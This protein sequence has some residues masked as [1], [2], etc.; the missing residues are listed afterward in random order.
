MDVAANLPT[1]LA[2]L[3]L[4][5]TLL[6]LLVLSLRWFRT[7]GPRP[8][9]HLPSPVGLAPG[10]A[11]AHTGVLVAEP[12]GR[13]VANGPARALFGL[14]G[15]QPTLSAVLRPTQP[16]DRLLELLAAEGQAQ[17][18]IGEH[19]VDATSHRVPVPAAGPDRIVVVLRE[20]ERP[21][22]NLPAGD[23][24]GAAVRAL[25]EIN[26]RLSAS[27]DVEETCDA[28]M[29][30]LAAAFQYSLAELNLWDPTAQVLR[31]AR[32]AGDQ[33]Y[34]RDLERAGATYGPDEGYSGWLA[35]HRAPLC[36]ENIP[37]FEAA[38]PKLYGA[39]FPFEAYLGVPLLAG[40]E[41]V[42]TLEL[43][44]YRPASFRPHD[45]DFLQLVAGQAA[46]A[47]RNAQR[48]A[49]EQRRA[50]E[51]AGL[52]EITR[53]LEAT[54]DARELFGR[55]TSDIARVMD[56]EMAALL[57]HSARTQALE[58]QP[59]FHGLPDIVA[60]VLRMPLAAGSEAEQLWTAG[61]HWSTASAATDPAIA[62]L[63]LRD[64]VD[65]AAPQ[66]LLL[67]VIAAGE[68][69]QGVVLVA[70]KHG[71]GPFG[72]ED[73]Q[74]LEAIAAQVATIFDN[75]RLVDQA[76]AR[77]DEAEVLRTIAAAAAGADLDSALRLAMQQAARLLEFELGMI[78]LLD[79]AR[80]EL[81]PHP[82]SVYGG[83]P[84]EAQ[85]MR[86][87]TSE[88]AF[89][90][91]ITR[92]R[93][94]FITG[95]AMRDR[96]L[97]G[98]YKH[99]T[100]H[101]QVNS[102]LAVPLVVGDHCLGE[103]IVVAHAENAFTRA[104]LRLLD[105]IG[106]Q[107]ASA[108]E[109][110]R[111][112][113][114]TDQKLQQRVEQLTALTRVSRELN[115]TV[116]LERILHLVHD[117]AIH[118]TH[119]DCGTLVLFDLASTN[120]NL[121]A[122]RL[123]DE[124]MG[125]LL[126]PLEAQ[127]AGG[128]AAVQRVSDLQAG[129]PLAAHEGVRSALVVPIA[130]RGQV[131]G[132][133]HL[134]RHDPA[135]FDEAAVEAAQA[136]AAQTA[137]AVENARRFEDQ[138]RRGELLRRR[139]DQLA[140]LFEV[141]R[142]V[143]SDLPLAENLEAIAF[144]LQEAVGFNIVIVSSLDPKSRRLRRMAATGL[145]LVTFEHISQ[146]E[147]PWD[148]VER[149]LREPYR[150]SQSY[151]LP[152]ETT[153]QLTAHLEP[154]VVR[155]VTAPGDG[156]I[157]WHP[158]DTVLTPLYG[159][160]MEAVGLLTA[161]NPRDG[162]RPDRNTI[163]VIE[164]FANQAAQAIE[165]A[166]LYEAAERRAAQLLA[167]H[168]VMEA[169][170][171]AANSAHLWQ[172]AAET[173]LAQLRGPDVC[174]LA[175]RDTSTSALALHGRA[176]TLSPDLQFAPL[177]AGENPLA[178][179]VA[180]REPVLTL[181]TDENDLSLNP[182]VA[183]LEV[184]SFVCVPIYSQNEPA[185]ALFV[186][187]R[188]RPEQP[189]PFA[190]ED[191]DVFTV[192][193][194]QL[195]ATLES[196]RLAADIR[197]R[198]AQ[199]AALAEASQD[200]TATLRTEDVVHAVLAGLRQV[201]EYDSVTLWLREHDKLRI[202]AAQGFENDA[203]RLGL[204]VEIADSAIFAELA[205]SLAPILVPEVR[206]DPRFV[207]G[208]FQ[209]TQS[210]LAAPLVS[211]GVILGVLAIDKAEPHFYTPQT[212][213]VLMAFASQAAVSLD[214]ARLF[215]ESE[216]DRQA[217]AE[218]SQRLALLNRVSAELGGTLQE[219]Q[220]HA[221]MLAELMGALHAQRALM[222]GV[223]EHGTARL[224]AQQPD[225]PSVLDYAVPAIERVR[226]AAAPLAVEDITREPLLASAVADLLARDTRSLLVVPLAVGGQVLAIVQVEATGQT[227]RFGL[228]EIELA[229]TLAN[230]GAV[231]VQNARLYAQT[232]RALTERTRAEQELRRRNDE[233]VALNR[234]T[235]AVTSELEMQVML[236]ATARELAQ[237]FQARN[238]GIALLNPA[239]THL[240]VIA[241]YSTRAEDA[242]TIGI[243]IPLEGNPSSIYVVETGQ[244][245]VLPKAY[246]HP[247]TAPIHG[248]L[249]ALNTQCL[250][251][252]PLRTRGEVV[253]TIGLDTDQPEREF[254]LAEVSLAETAAGQIAG[255]VEN[256]QFA[257]QLEARV[258]ART[259]ELERARERVQVL[260]QITTELSSSLD[261]DLVLSR[262]LT[263]VS[264][265][266][267]A[268][269]GSIYLLDLGTNQ[270]VYRAALGRATPL[271]PGGLP[272][273]FRRSEGLVGS[274]LRS[275][276]G[277][278][279]GNLAHDERWT[280]LPD[281]DE[282]EYRSALV[283]PL[284]A[285]E[286]ALGAMVLLSPQ[287][288][289]F[290]QDQLKLVAAATNQV[291][292]A[293]NNAEL[294]RLIRD[295]AERLGGMLRSQ[296]VEAT[297]SRAI[298]EG[299]AD[300]VLVTGVRGEVTVFNLA[301]ERILRLQREA[302]IGRP[303][304]EFVGI[305]GA[306]GQ[307]WISAV[308]RWSRTP[309]SYQP[310]EFVAQRIDLEDNRRVISVHLAPVIANDEYL[311]SVSVI[312]DI[313]REV[314]VD[315]LK[316]EFVTNVSHELRTPMTS[317]KGY[318]DLLLMGAAGPMAENQTRFLEV[319]RGNADRLSLLVNDLLDISR[320][321]SGKIQLTLR[322]VALEEVIGEVVAN[323]RGR[324][325]K[326]G[327]PM[328]LT[329]RT[330]PELP[331]VLGDRERIT[332]IVMNLADNAFNYTHPE[333]TIVLTAA[334]NTSGEHV[335][336]EVVDTGVGVSPEDQPR[337][338]DRFYRGDDALVLATAGTGLGLAIARQL[339]EMHGGRLWLARSE[340][341]KGSTFALALPVKKSNW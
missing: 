107:L 162:Q 72:A 8:A 164:I 184:R 10:E 101:F 198:A 20:A 120:D 332:Q 116:E 227:R 323:L 19:R 159:S 210:W 237:I 293:I 169:A 201:V 54:S 239:R 132:L 50:A 27:L 311:G 273:P 308:D 60:E 137:I 177:L 150:V 338:F 125:P 110:L 196:G 167:L 296:Q 91:S 163:E 243:E 300:G 309:S 66:T 121:V 320:I 267:K 32:H 39:D 43:A 297:K 82:A 341:G 261:L 244:S 255:A 304:T 41:L 253:G 26:R 233:L 170:S 168:R 322:P 252:V 260:L 218:R 18:S 86:L 217:I 155:Q 109:R 280:P 316:S 285:G 235:M 49:A 25:A 93:R 259:I 128:E 292:A 37:A 185:G 96:R 80:G 226:E 77:A 69:R 299:I 307:S 250:M 63:G 326:E 336:V 172:T 277:V 295:Q 21:A 192:L 291:A 236:R 36:I 195:G 194:N 213:Q 256:A 11:E 289:A 214:N 151:F 265:A 53:A 79:E 284:M 190:P 175:L 126:S 122:V 247:L 228:A 67:T 305:Y 317:I 74:R 301:C 51:L 329:V 294:Y 6:G 40:N 186:G 207:G 200:I 133:M 138:V 4:G 158:A 83:P 48:Y 111:L 225:E 97:I 279:I 105:T 103:I 324:S 204:R 68:Q 45:A 56:V 9:H 241:D 298:L 78:V 302:V 59:P 231:A 183:A 92:T 245:L 161:H 114:T 5:T 139:A 230:Q 15:D 264:E 174:L 147:T 131:V 22:A 189:S 234:V 108:I 182:F 178:S 1:A 98:F 70:N 314:E 44:H 254:T 23:P 187:A 215:E 127:L 278:L 209:P 221:V 306:A 129:S 197:Q 206:A 29:A 46:L 64:F 258:A 176:G 81:V 87:S 173:L 180:S 55:L 274:V 112:Y 222:I 100:E 144:G 339:A 153:A 188:H 141:S 13:L 179:V 142:S 75:V 3:G 240:T 89:E 73:V 24:N 156:A 287:G 238:C 157:A 149:V 313:T 12:G 205:T 143:R 135:G 303:F 16:A 282:A 331:T 191:L 286:D 171:V 262:A 33:G 84:E 134:H 312:R 117:E 104:D 208:E 154:P 95:R 76:R 216:Q 202:V 14:N 263:F 71:G 94:P 212:T 281:H 276:Q 7:H 57:R 61:G 269:R 288:D 203:E 181:N 166:R 340:P 42:G 30:G 321:E 319:I 99:L 34:P 257:Q 328:R 124:Y 268:T 31:P 220:I 85:V 224:A 113:T 136:L 266:I 335:V 35:T 88:P 270:L 249:R 283:V 318:A 272:A 17:L 65:S 229:Q 62:S 251:I 152:H 333:G 337:L 130:V 211:K 2:A 310:G 325:E 58:A 145:P 123:G 232:Q 119:A 223:D 330:E 115:Q 199:L 52:T 47:L 106:T 219:E 248:L 290:D 193:A 246:E 275:R 146:I 271:P 148:E 140:Q 315:R 327:K 242:S 165:N 160:H 38:R 28:I 102:A 90:Y 118:T 334:T